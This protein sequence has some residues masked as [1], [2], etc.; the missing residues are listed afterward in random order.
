MFEK[1]KF[2]PPMARSWHRPASA[3]GAVTRRRRRL[4]IALA[5]V[6]GLLLTGCVAQ[7]NAEATPLRVFAT[8]GYLAD[9]AARIAPD[10]RIVTMVGPGGDP[11]SY[12]P[13][14]R[15]IEWVLDADLVLWNGLGLEAQM[16]DQLESLGIRQVAVA[17]ALP[18]ERL[19]RLDDTGGADLYDPHV[20]NDPELWAEAIGVIAEAFAERDP[21][22][23]DRYRERGAAFAAEVRDAGARARVDLES[24]PPPR[25][26]ITG[27]DAFGYFGRAFDL[28][29]LAT[30]F[31]STEAALSPQE[32]HRLATLI[33]TE[34]IP[35]IFH[36]NQAN[37]QAIQSLRE[38]VLALG[39]RVKISD[40]EL[41]ADSLGARADVDEYLEV[42]DHH[43][44][45]IRRELGGRGT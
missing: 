36:D 28:R 30:D 17:E 18:A 38:A 21:S 40:A 41:F 14:T 3:V 13:S 25:V 27:H 43:A 23:A 6:A 29:V 33:A 11:H 42:L 15:D 26:L 9:A 4:G 12:Q 32:L 7:G 5:V 31:I 22:A 2:S 19:I 10:A 44:R 45:T 39:W 37:P 34:R 20:W 8:T 16:E 35:V 1:S 24:V